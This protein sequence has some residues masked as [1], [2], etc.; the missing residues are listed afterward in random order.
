MITSFA[1]VFEAADLQRTASDWDNLWM[2]LPDATW[3]WTMEGRTLAVRNWKT[4]LNDPHLQAIAFCLI[5]QI[6][7]DGLWLRS[8]WG[9]RGDAPELVRRMRELI[10]AA[11]VDGSAGTAFDAGNMLPRLDLEAQVLLAGFFGGNGWATQAWKP[12]RP[13]ADGRGT[14]WR[15]IDADRVETP[16]DKL[17][18]GVVNGIRYVDGAAYSIYV[19]SFD[20]SAWTS[21]RLTSPTYQEIPIHGADGLRNVVHFAPFRWRADGDL[22]VPA[23][24]SGVLLAHQLRKL[25]AAHV[26]GKRIQASHPIITESAN[27]QAA[28]AAYQAAVDAGDADADVQML[29][30]NKGSNTQFTNAQYQGNDMQAVVNVYLRALTASIGYPWQY[31]MCQLTDANM[32][33]AQAA[34]DQAERT[35]SIYQRQWLEQAGSHFDYSLIREAWAKGTFGDVPFDR[36][37]LRC[38]WQRPRRSDA[39]RLRSRQAAVLGA[40][41]GMSMSTIHDELGTDFDDEQIKLAEN[42]AVAAEHGNQ[43]LPDRPAAAPAISISTSLPPEGSDPGGQPNAQPGGDGGVPANDGGAP[44]PP[45]DQQGAP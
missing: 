3:T 37:L 22:G 13:G 27:P 33:A 32:A 10:N 39:N 4:L 11:V 15:S 14:C 42:R 8:S 23:L 7:G 28:A 17:Q 38:T 34:L 20:P 29:F 21:W 35:S 30:V 26:S 12:N 41:L 40:S 43:F 36:Q 31:V 5:S 16:P 6:L 18:D 25:F 19:R 44:L 1:R 45:S 9:K 2:Y 24:A